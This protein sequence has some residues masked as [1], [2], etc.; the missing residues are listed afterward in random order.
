MTSKTSASD[1]A[2]IIPEKVSDNP[3]IAL[4]GQENAVIDKVEERK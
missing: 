3:V 1:I 4:E 2:T